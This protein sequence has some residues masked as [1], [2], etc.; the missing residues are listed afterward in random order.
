MIQMTTAE[1]LKMVTTEDGHHHVQFAFGSHP[2][3]HVVH[4]YKKFL[5]HVMHLLL[6][7]A[8]ARHPPPPL[9]PSQ[10]VPAEHFMNDVKISP[11]GE[12][13]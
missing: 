9:Q 7:P 8:N 11:S 5:H 6:S 13:R 10:C 1:E 12:H 4:P 3:H 2:C